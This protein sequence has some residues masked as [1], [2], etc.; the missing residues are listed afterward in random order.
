MTDEMRLKFYQNKTT[1][2]QA[3]KIRAEKLEKALK[4]KQDEA[5]KRVMKKPLPSTGQYDAM[6][7]A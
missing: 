6:Y 2:N 4:N 7:N 3:N 1:N 5:I